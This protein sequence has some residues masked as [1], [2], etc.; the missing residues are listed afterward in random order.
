MRGLHPWHTGTESPAV[1]RC[2]HLKSQTMGKNKDCPK[3]M[4]VPQHESYRAARPEGERP[5]A[6]VAGDTQG[7]TRARSLCLCLHLEEEVQ[8]V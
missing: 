6:A 2:S 7:T 5:P 1:W 4:C 3:A 8:K